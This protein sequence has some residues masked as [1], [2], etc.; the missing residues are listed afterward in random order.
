MPTGWTFLPTRAWEVDN[1]PEL[2]QRAGVHLV[3]PPGSPRERGH[4]T[5]SGR[6]GC[7]R[8]RLPA[9]ILWATRPCGGRNTARS[10]PGPVSY[11]AKA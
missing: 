4:R 3:L 2:F 9:E 7:W 1:L 10:W 5:P 6:R 8:R 11:C